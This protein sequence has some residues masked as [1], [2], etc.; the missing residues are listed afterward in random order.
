ME[1][2][3]HWSLAP[4]RLGT[5]VLDILRVFKVANFQEKSIVLSDL[6]PYSVESEKF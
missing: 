5:M 6:I 2:Q 3:E 1:K 4:K